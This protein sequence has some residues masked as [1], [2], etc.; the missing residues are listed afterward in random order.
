MDLAVYRQVFRLSS[1]S[2]LFHRLLEQRFSEDKVGKYDQWC[3]SAQPEPPEPCKGKRLSKED[4]RKRGKCDNKYENIYRNRYDRDIDYV[5]DD[6]FRPVV[7][8]S[9]VVFQ[10]IKPCLRTGSH[11]CRGF[12]GCSTAMAVGRVLVELCAAFPD[13]SN[14]SHSG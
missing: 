7:L 3:D 13:V 2:A 1:P 14:C 12:G 11:G 4:R 5:G 10:T 6:A 9:P 8:E